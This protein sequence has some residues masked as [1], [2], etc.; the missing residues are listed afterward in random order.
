M[1]KLPDLEKLNY[2]E[3]QDLIRNAQALLTE[4]QASA[5]NELKESFAAKARE[6]GISL[7]DLFGKGRRGGKGSVAVK[8]RDP[9]NA[10]N[11]WTGRGRMP[12]WLQAAVHAGR[13]KESYLIK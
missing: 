8:Y 9:K 4:K 6:H 1:A 7:E 2:V 12:R 3:L 10:E 13:K 11:T 5:R